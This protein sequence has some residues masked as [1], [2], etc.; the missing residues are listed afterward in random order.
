MATK[1]VQAFSNVPYLTLEREE[2]ES[3]H[4]AHFFRNVKSLEVGFGSKVMRVDRDGLWLGAEQFASAPFRVDMEGNVTATSVT[5]SGYIP[6]GGALDDIGTGNI[7]GTYIANGAIVTDK[8]AANAVVAD[9]IASNSVTAAKINVSTL[10]AISA[11]IG[12]ITAGSIT[13]VTITGGTV[14]TASSGDRIVLD[15]SNNDI[16]IYNGSTRR[17]RGYQQGWEFYNPSGTLIGE[18]YAS[19]S[20]ELLL[21]GNLVSGGKIFYGVASNGTHSMHVGTS[22]ST[23]R[24]YLDDNEMYLGNASDFSFDVQIFGVLNINN[25]IDMDDDLDWG[26]N[27]GNIWLHDGVIAIDSGFFRL[28]QMSG[29]EADARSDDSVDGNMYYR[30]DDDVIRVRLNG[31]WRTIT[32]S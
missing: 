31:T 25:G 13:G 3:R 28:A 10:S 5:L 18:I 32:T 4:G 14:R 1:E 16:S 29:A 19:S 2:L 7:T 12:T 20:N 30:T 15:G 8:L 24:F 11:N 27:D 26:I 9:K 17:A 22:G 23:L 6:T 21:A